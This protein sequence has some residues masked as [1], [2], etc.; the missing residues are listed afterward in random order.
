MA[1]HSSIPAWRIPI[2]R[3]AWQATVHGVAELDMT[4]RLSTRTRDLDHVPWSPQE[5]LWDLIQTSPHVQSWAKGIRRWDAHLLLQL[6]LKYPEGPGGYCVDNLLSV[7]INK[8]FL[9]HSHTFFFF[10]LRICAIGI[11]S[12]NGSW[13]VKTET[14]WSSKPWIFTLWPLTEKL[15]TSALDHN[16]WFHKLCEK[17]WS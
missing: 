8:V 6:S 17:S 14:L 1:N 10:F 16:W 5:A 9:E 4:E 13:M 12:Y 15:L 11:L 7:F 2:D 3:G